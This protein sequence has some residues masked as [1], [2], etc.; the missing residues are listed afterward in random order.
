MRTLKILC[1]VFCAMG[2]ASAISGVSAVSFTPGRTDVASHDTA[3]SIVA[4]SI[5]AFF[6]LA[7]FGIHSRHVA[8]WWLGWVVLFALL[9]DSLYSALSFGFGLPAQERWMVFTG[10]LLI[11][12][13]LFAS[14]A[15]WWKRQRTYFDATPST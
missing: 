6:L 12:A 5:S 3:G 4:L 14:G 13:L 10:A 11:A 7:W 2:V 15:W 9:G 1:L 8:T